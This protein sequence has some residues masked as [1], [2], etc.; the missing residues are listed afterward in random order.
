MENKKKEKPKLTIA[1]INKTFGAAIFV[2]VFIFTFLVTSN[3]LRE[4][5][6]ILLSVFGGVVAAGIIAWVTMILIL[7]NRKKASD[8]NKIKID[9]ALRRQK[10]EQKQKDKKVIDESNN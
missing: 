2:L 4:H 8:P 6:V 3:D 9:E 5:W 10:E 7:R 1:N